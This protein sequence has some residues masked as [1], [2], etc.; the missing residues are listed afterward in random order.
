MSAR[1]VLILGG[2]VEAVELAKALDGDPGFEPITSLAGRTRHPASVPGAVR[3][4]GFGGAEGLADYLKAN[5]IDALV[6]ATHPYAVRITQNAVTA[7]AAAGIPRLRLDR[8]A[9]TRLPD[10]RW[11]DVSDSSEAARHL[12]EGARR[13]FLAIGRQ[14]L[15][16]FAHRP[17][18]WFL[19]RVIDPPDP[20]P[21]L[22]RHEIVL[23]RGPFS[24]EAELALLREHRIDTIVS[25][26]SGG[27]ATYA[28]IVAGRKLRLPIVMIR[29]PLA[30]AGDRVETIAEALDWLGRADLR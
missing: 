14:D 16:P 3:I 28:K 1:R 30:P 12:P 24:T 27:D 8:P 17:D 26:N 9:W 13:V 21:G 2:T 10:D 25:K 4:G 11:I 23:G 19:L 5:A 22:D 7:C 6:D 18:I 29:R 15:E 20:P